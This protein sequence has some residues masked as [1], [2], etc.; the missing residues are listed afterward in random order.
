M[1]RTNGEAGGPRKKRL[2]G[3]LTGRYVRPAR[4]I[5]GPFSTIK[6]AKF[7]NFFGYACCHGTKIGGKSR[8][9]GRISC[10][11]NFALHLAHAS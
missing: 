3:W 6:S 1:K 5:K 9:Q 10:C 2:R 8:K 7:K 4:G 11:D